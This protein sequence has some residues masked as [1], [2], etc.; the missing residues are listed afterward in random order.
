MKR[1]HAV[2]LFVSQQEECVCGSCFGLTPFILQVQNDSFH[3]EHAEVFPKKFQ[4]TDAATAPLRAFIF[5]LC[6][7]STNGKKKKTKIC[8]TFQ[9][10]C[11]ALKTAVPS[12]V[13]AAPFRHSLCLH[14][15]NAELVSN[16][17]IKEIRFLTGL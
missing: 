13:A 4:K 2:T 7:S 15:N 9:S 5:N 8:L 14:I 17:Y 1:N 10:S 16:S 3:S 12:C 6:D 11:H